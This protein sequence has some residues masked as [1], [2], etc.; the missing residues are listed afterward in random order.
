ML[1]SFLKDVYFLK[2]NRYPNLCSTEASEYKTPWNHLHI[3][4]THC[5]QH[6]WFLLCIKHNVR[7]TTINNEVFRT[8]FWEHVKAW[9]RTVPVPWKRTVFFVWQKMR[10]VPRS[11]FTQGFKIT[12]MPGTLHA[13]GH[14]THL[15]HSFPTLSVLCPPTSA[16]GQENLRCSDP[17]NSELWK[18]SFPAHNCT[19][20]R[21][22]KERHPF[23]ICWSS[24]A[25]WVQKFP[26]FSLWIYFRP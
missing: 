19:W 21:G 7:A 24:V 13:P 25:T 1:H 5:C 11:G 8:C 17:V 4:L 15:F 14:I 6:L 10:P 26:Y 16:L 22:R 18:S 23:K 12:S 20:S 2:W 3:Y 9:K